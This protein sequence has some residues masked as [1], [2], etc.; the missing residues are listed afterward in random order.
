MAQAGGFTPGGAVVGGPGEPAVVTAFVEGA[1]LEPL[2]PERAVGADRESGEVGPVFHQQRGG[3]D[4]TRR[5]PGGGGGGEG[6]VPEGAFPGRETGAAPGEVERAA[7]V[8]EEAG[9]TGVGAGRARDRL[10]DR[11]GGTDEQGGREEGGGGET[12]VYPGFHDA[13][14]RLSFSFSYSFSFFGAGAC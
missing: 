7:G 9:F 14:D 2:G 4:G 3:N 13:G 6:G 8:A 1:G 10:Q 5:R 12:A 11:H